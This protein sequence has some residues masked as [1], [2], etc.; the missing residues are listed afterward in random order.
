MCIIILLEQVKYVL[1]SSMFS[2]YIYL[3]KYTF[4]MTKKVCDEFRILPNLVLVKLL[5]GE[6]ILPP[7]AP[8]LHNREMHTFW[9]IGAW[10]SGVPRDGMRGHGPLLHGGDAW[11]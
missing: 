5:N 1:Y 2:L 4:I 3:E 10:N 9:A 6:S 8:S 7:P 11:F